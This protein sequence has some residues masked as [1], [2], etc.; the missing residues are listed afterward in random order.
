[1][2]T[3]LAVSAALAYTAGGYYMKLSSGLTVLAPTCAVFAWFAVGA[4]LQTLA[5]RHE[6]MTVTYVVVLGLEA[7]AA[8][9]VGA[10]L[11]DEPSSAVKIVGIVL[12]VTGIA[13]LRWQPT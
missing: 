9:G 4:A 12:V 11:L 6:S 5:M 3:L 7:I 13:L 10:L 2:I 1:M 8:Y